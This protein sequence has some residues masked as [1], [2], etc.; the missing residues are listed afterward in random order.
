MAVG[1][2]L[3]KS[4]IAEFQRLFEESVRAEARPEDLLDSVSYDG[5]VELGELG[6]D[7]FAYYEKLGPFGFACL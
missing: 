4:K 7:F 2:G 5:V 6:P 3:H 1:L